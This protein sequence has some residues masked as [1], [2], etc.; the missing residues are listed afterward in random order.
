[1]CLSYVDKS[2]LMHRISPVLLFKFFNDDK[3]V[4]E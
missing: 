4:I 1:V 2:V 3:D